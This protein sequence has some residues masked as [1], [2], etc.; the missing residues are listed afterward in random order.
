MS[1]ALCVDSGLTFNSILFGIGLAFI[2]KRGRILFA[3]FD[4]A[5]SVLLQIML[6]ALW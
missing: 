1:R 4:A 3:A 6:V 2:G 5:F